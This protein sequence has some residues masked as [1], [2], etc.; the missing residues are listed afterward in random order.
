MWMYLLTLEE[1]TEWEKGPEPYSFMRQAGKGEP[2]EAENGWPEIWEGSSESQ[3]E[4]VVYQQL[5]E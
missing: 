2:E 4:G 5:Q 1:G 3:K